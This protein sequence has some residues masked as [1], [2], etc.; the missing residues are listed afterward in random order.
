MPAKK[1]RVPAT[2]SAAGK[3]RPSATAETSPPAKGPAA[4]AKKLGAL[5]A[6]ALVLREA[7]QPLSCPELIAQ[8]AAKGYWTSPKGLTPAAT[9]YAAIARE[10]QR[11]GAASRF[12]QTGPGRFAAPGDARS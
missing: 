9:L 6:A 7:G 10:V 5:D 3:K 8:M 11:K 1:K 2:A 4:P 12:V